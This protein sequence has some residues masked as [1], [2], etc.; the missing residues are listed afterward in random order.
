MFKSLNKA[1]V[2]HENFGFL[3]STDLL[4]RSLCK[5]IYVRRVSYYDQW[6][7]A[8][9]VKVGN[10]SPNGHTRGAP[11]SCM[12]SSATFN[13]ML[14]TSKIVDGSAKNKFIRYTFRIFT[15]LKTGRSHLF[16]KVGL[17]TVH[18][19]LR[20]IMRSSLVKMSET[21]YTVKNIMARRRI[22][23]ERPGHVH[24][25]YMEGKKGCSKWT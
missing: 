5:E 11:F 8:V 17:C 20:C 6:G 21:L 14:V 15:N 10:Q 3:R 23:Q 2:L 16:R 4:L 9:L 13:N 25:T 19:H 24:D 18:I 12:I 22:V 7:L 1:F